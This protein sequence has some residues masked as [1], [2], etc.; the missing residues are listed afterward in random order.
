MKGSR[1]EASNSL[2]RSIAELA[3]TIALYLFV[4]TSV[5]QGNVIPTPSMEPTLLVGDHVLVDRTVFAP[6]ENSV[7]GRLLPYREIERGD[8][9]V[10][11]Y[12]LDESELYVKR[13]TAVP[14]DRVRISDGRL[15]VNGSE[16]DEPYKVHR[17]QDRNLYGRDFPPAR[18][19]AGLPERG[20]RMLRGHVSD[21]ELIVPDGMY[22]ALG[23]NRDNSADS[24]YWGFVPRDSIVGSPSYVYWS[25][26]APSEQWLD[27][28]TATHLLDLAL[29]LPWKTRWSRMLQPVPS[30]RSRN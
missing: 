6:K 20:A 8:V 22:F 28:F 1:T 29:N 4:T 3:S 30:A 2:A 15:Y 24:R 27:R 14:G 21:G 16:V 11:R 18:I 17:F 25:F 5:V 13:A 12:P 23:D 19:P 7:L 9:I 10:F 26:D